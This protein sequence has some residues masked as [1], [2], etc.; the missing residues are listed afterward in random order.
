MCELTWRVARNYSSQAWDVDQG[1]NTVDDKDALNAKG[2]K[3]AEAALEAD[4][5][6][7]HAH[8]WCVLGWVRNAECRV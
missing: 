2:A 3:Y 6:S 7:S 1:R 4:K 5:S 8:K